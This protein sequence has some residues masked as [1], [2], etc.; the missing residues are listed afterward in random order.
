MRNRIVFISLTL[1]GCLVGIAVAQSVLH[2]RQLGTLVVNMN[3]VATVTYSQLDKTPVKAGSGSTVRI[4]LP[5]GVYQ[6]LASAK[7]GYG[8]TSTP[9]QV[10]K[11]KLTT[12]SLS[13]IQPV[14]PQ[15]VALYTGRDVHELNNGDLAFVNS[16]FRLPSIIGHGTSTAQPYRTELYPVDSITWL[17]DQTGYASSNQGDWTYFNGVST[18]KLPVSGAEGRVAKTQTSVNSS[19][20]VA[21][22]I[23]GGLYLLTGPTAAPHKLLSLGDDSWTPVLSSTGTTLVFDSRETADSGGGSVRSSQLVLAD[24]TKQSVPASL[25]QL[26]AASWSPDGT[27]LVALK[28]SGLFL[29]NASS[30]SVTQQAVQ[31]PTNSSSVSWVDNDRFL[32]VQGGRVWLVSVSKNVIQL[33]SNMPGTPTGTNPFSL[34][35]DGHA[36]YFGSTPESSDG[37]YI[38]K[39]VLPQ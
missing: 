37:G 38:Y 5:A 14:A 21:F 36:V 11:R 4:R 22:V 3:T 9:A 18:G 7:A 32:Y 28:T 13:I 33:M 20:G 1:I 34:S 8:Q 19:G 27:K 39:L 25:S 30:N 2:G 17:S 23:D 26:T 29:Y 16:P 10:E 24:G 12:I 6:I 31:R 35:R 15:R